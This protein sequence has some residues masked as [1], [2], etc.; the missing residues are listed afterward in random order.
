MMK[1]VRSRWRPASENNDE[2]KCNYDSAEFKLNA[3]HQLMPQN[4]NFEVEA[5]E[6]KLE[7]NTMDINLH[8]ETPISKP[9]P[10][11]V[12]KDFPREY[13][14]AIGRLNRFNTWKQLNHHRGLKY[15]HLGADQKFLI[16]KCGRLLTGTFAKIFCMSNAWLL[17]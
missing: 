12:Y 6:N 3:Y 17:D 7:A 11:M 10:G 8:V 16:E 1:K 2:M 13:Y 9:L 15:I 4:P 14:L 5:K